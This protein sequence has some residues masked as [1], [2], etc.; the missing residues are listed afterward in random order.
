M[1]FVF[2]WLACFNIITSWPKHTQRRPTSSVRHLPNVWK[3]IPCTALWHCW[4]HPVTHA[5]PSSC[6]PC[7]WDWDPDLTRLRFFCFGEA[8]SCLAIIKHPNR[9]II[10]ERGVYFGCSVPRNLWPVCSDSKVSTV[11]ILFRKSVV[12]DDVTVARW[13]WQLKRTWD[14]NEISHAF[15]EGVREIQPQCFASNV[16]QFWCRRILSTQQNL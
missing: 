16:F 1:T 9:S 7:S 11:I 10:R 4:C 8:L 13:W 2:L 6:S 3:N 5:L 12:R 14:K 15:P